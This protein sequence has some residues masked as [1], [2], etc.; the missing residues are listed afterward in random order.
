VI[1][2]TPLRTG[3]VPRAAAARVRAAERRRP[4]ALRSLVKKE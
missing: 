2:L 4:W 1:R 3:F